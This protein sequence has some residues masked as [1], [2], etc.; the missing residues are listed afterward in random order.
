MTTSEL[1]RAPRRLAGVRAA[2]ALALAVGGCSGG[3]ETTTGRAFPVFPGAAIDQA[4]TEAANALAANA[5]Q[6]NKVSHI[7]MASAPYEAVVAF[8][9]EKGVEAAVPPIPDASRWLPDGTE[10]RRT[11]F[12]LDG[13]PDL[14]GSSLWVN[15]QRPYVGNVRSEG[16]RPVF[17]DVRDVTTIAV[18]E[19]R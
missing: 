6:A 1:Q 9:R 8:Y 14:Q 18:V 10:I 15:V 13:A 11:V 17:E 3:S 4:A 5:G 12:I 16:D 19:R 7:Y 2:L